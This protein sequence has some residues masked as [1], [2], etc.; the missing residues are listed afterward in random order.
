MASASLIF[1]GHII[2]ELSRNIP[3]SLF[4]LNELIKN[5]YDA[6]SPDVLIKISPKNNTVT[7]TDR[8]NG[9]EESE[10][11]SLFHLSKS[12][13]KYGQEIEQDGV[14]RIT[15]GSKGLGFLSAFK[16]GDYVEWV[17]CKNGVQSKFSVRK[18][19]LVSKDDIAGTEI[20]ITTG[21]NDKKGTIITIYSSK[22]EIEELL[23]DLNLDDGKVI[24][25][26]AATIID[27][28]FN[29]IVEIENLNK[30]V[31]TKSLSDFRREEEKNQLFYIKYESSKHEI[32]VF[33]KG[34]L[35]D[36][37]EFQLRRTDYSIETELIVFYFEKGEN[38]KDISALNKRIHDNALSPLVYINRNLFNNTV[39]F[40][41]EV[42]RKKSS[43][44]TLPQ[45]IGRVSIT[46]QSTELEF[47]SDRTNFVDNSL[48]KDIIKDLVDLNKKI[49]SRGAEIKKSLRVNEKIPTGKAMPSQE[50]GEQKNR[51]AS[52]ILDKKKPL[53]FSIPSEH[54]MLDDYI[55]QAKDS[56]G[57][58][59]QKSSVKLMVDGNHLVN[60]LIPSIEDPCEKEVFF[61]YEDENTELISRSL[62]FV[63]EKKYSN[64]SGKTSEKSL[65]TIQSSSGY[66]V[67]ME[68]V[69]DLIKAADIAYSSKSREELLPLIACS[70]RSI[71][72]I[73]SE[74]VIKERRTWFSK[75]DAKKLGSITKREMKDKLLLNV[76][77]TIILLKKNPDIIREISNVTGI[78]FPNLSNL[79]NIEDFKVAVKKSHIGAH[80]STRFLSKPKVEAS[81]DSCGLFAVIC[82]VLINLEKTSLSNIQLQKVDEL[83]L[84]KYLGTP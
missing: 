56:L 30:Q 49:Q 60:R 83:D 69:S 44:E 20:P 1:S 80:Q 57:Q 28:S 7:I 24:E 46:C 77:H 45:M 72:E 48:T 81:A 42:L 70:I 15:Q 74:K 26:L 73:S 53:L 65:F 5:A 78:S 9:M 41:P 39:V 50:S 55:I 84:D 67:K 58:E 11:K 82:D 76:V 68:T 66:D 2:E 36:S 33:H 43:K 40:D 17:T 29:I 54:I 13:K 37:I 32:D 59:I 18:S 8:G 62:V 63:F 14:K 75:F 12:K 19:D 23:S 52:I 71:F 61:R 6:F 4:A 10:I 35:I 34:E 38:S 21:R 16:F 27:K 3:S 51:A 47:N 31:S 22:E 64:I 25:K 79:L